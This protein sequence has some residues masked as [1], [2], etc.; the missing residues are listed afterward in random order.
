MKNIFSNE[1]GYTDLKIK[2]NFHLLLVFSFIS[3]CSSNVT[4]LTY[5]EKGSTYNRNETTEKDISVLDKEYSFNDKALTQSYLLRKLNKWLDTGNGGINTNGTQL[6][7]EIIYARNKHP[8]LF[9]AI[10]SD[11]LNLRTAINSVDE[12]VERKAIDP[13]FENF[14][15]AAIPP[16]FKG[17]FQVNTYTTGNQQRTAIAVES[18]GDFV[19]TWQSNLQDNSNNG[20]FARRYNKAGVPRSPELQV[21]T[22]T[23]GNQRFPSVA[24]DSTG[25]FVITW[26]SNGQDGESYGIYA[27]RYNR[28]GFIQG[29]EFRVNSYTTGLQD[30]PSVAM[31]STGDFVISW[32]SNGQDGDSYGIYAQRYSSTGSPAG[33]E[34]RVNNFTTSTQ[35]FPAIAMDYD[36]DFVITWQSLQDGSSYGVYAQRY[37]AAGEAQGSEFRANSYTTDK[38]LNPAVAMDNSGDFVITWQSLNNQDGSQYG[39][40]AQRYDQSG[41]KQNSEFPVNT[42]T[43]DRQIN[44]SIA[45]DSFGDFVIAWESRGQDLSEDGSYVQMYNNAGIAQGVEFRANTYT[46]GFQILPSIGLDSAGDFVVTWVSGNTTGIGQDGSSAG[47]YT[48]IYDNT[49]TVK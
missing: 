19:V 26:E 48:K 43:T 36:G 10:L 14:L 42:Y 11:D 9:L 24:V 44:P 13:V 17:E 49:G 46:T 27:Q 25:D 7:K 41:I 37:N 2:K 32:E 33:S 16:V 20:I 6:V 35:K 39:I 4:P 29:S 8:N 30:K 15:E 34:F 45:M 12:V 18:D 31:D 28:S 38:Q 3:A 5:S 47:V 40:F 23:T 22:F 1:N 21:N